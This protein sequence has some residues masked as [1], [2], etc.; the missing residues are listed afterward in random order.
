MASLISAQQI[1]R[2]LDRVAA[3][4]H[5][6]LKERERLLEE[7]TQIQKRLSRAPE[8]TELLDTLGKELFSTT[9]SLVEQHLTQALQDILEQPISL[10]AERTFKH[11]TIGVEFYIERDQQREHILK[12]QGGSVSNILSVGLRMLAL[13]ML[14]P[15]QHRP[16]LVLDEQDCW[17]RPELVPRFAQMI[18]AAADELQLQV[19]VISHH[20]PD[21]FQGYAD[22][23]YRVSSEADHSFR[24]EG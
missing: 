22:R 14:D 15:K 5:T 20:P 16:L 9:I 17:L 18:K 19:L 1:R 2:R 24:I 23:I 13:T 3:S 7:R 10:K 21:Y 11:G 8:I 4:R 6:L 12:G